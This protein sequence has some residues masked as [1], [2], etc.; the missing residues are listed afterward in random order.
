MELK[1]SVSEESL[2]KQ[3]Y[4]SNLYQH[5]R[6]MVKKCRWQKNQSEQKD[7]ECKTLCAIDISDSE[8]SEKP[9]VL[10]GIFSDPQVEDLNQLREQ[11]III[12]NLNLG[13]NN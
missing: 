1:N 12:T 9:N 6:N 2:K 5:G 4:N 8:V 11:D 3:G 10:R 7:P 13:K